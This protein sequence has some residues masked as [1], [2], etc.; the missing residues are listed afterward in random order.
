[1]IYKENLPAS[2]V[3]YW[4]EDLALPRHDFKAPIYEARRSHL[5]PG[6][7]VAGEKIVHMHRD[8]TWHPV[9]PPYQSRSKVQMF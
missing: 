2:L 5:A 6:S 4:W 9:K 8:K 1:M 7:P 3:T